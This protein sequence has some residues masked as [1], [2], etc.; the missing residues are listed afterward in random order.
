MNHKYKLKDYKLKHLGQNLLLHPYKTLFWREQ[1]ILF[2]SDLHIGKAAH[3]R[4]SGVPIPEKVHESDFSRLEHVIQAYNPQRL[5]FLGDLFHSMHNT[6]WE[7]FKIF[8]TKKI[9]IKPELVVGNHDILDEHQYSFLTLHTNY[10]IIK[11]YLLSHK[12][13]PENMISDF[14]NLC[15]HLHPSVKLRGGARQSLSVACFY[16]GKKHGILPAFGNF[17]GSSKLPNWE[18][19]DQIFAITENQVIPLHKNH[20]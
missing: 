20:N 2:L 8:I 11:P 16:F 13:L 15:G 19:S 12:P 1:N 14:Y 6:T 10:V 4:K 17:T 3:F 18:K 9:N 5:I 7:A